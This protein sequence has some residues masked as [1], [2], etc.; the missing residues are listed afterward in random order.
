[1]NR[2]DFCIR[3]AW[4]RGVDAIPV[5]VEISMSEALPG[6]SVLGMTSRDERDVSYRVRCAIRAC[7]FE[8]PRK[9][10]TVNLA[11]GDTKKAGSGFDLPIAAAILAA[12]AQIPTQGLDNTLFAGEL[13][14]YGDVSAVRGDIAY[15]VLARD[16]SLSFVGGLGDSQVTLAG[17]Q[18]L[19]LQK[20]SDL[21]RGIEYLPSFA[22]QEAVANISEGIDFAEVHGQETAKRA[23]TIAAAGE[24]GM[25]MVG[26]PG[27][28]KS[29]LAER[30]TTILPPITEQEQLAALCIHSIAGNDIEPILA[31]IRPFRAPHHTT[32]AVGLVGGGRPVS[33][34]E[35]SLAHGGV[36]FLDEMAEFSANILQTLRQPMERGYVR[37]VRAEGG[38]CFPC[39]FQLLAASNP[40][41]CGYLGDREV[42]CKC[43]D[44]AVLRYQEKLRGPLADRIDI[45]VDIVRP[46]AE[47]IIEG[48]HS[49]SSAEM[50]EQVVCGRAFAKWRIQN[51]GA[52]SADVSKEKH[53]DDA[54]ASFL[55]ENAAKKRLIAIARATHMTGRGIN[56][57][58]RIARTIADM[59]ES[60]RVE[61][62]HVL[63]AS[64]FRGRRD[65]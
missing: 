31:G 40:C 7:G 5:T 49:T 50:C 42:P 29:M 4:I 30:M 38:Y 9:A 26:S 17:A 48:S 12:T 51:R 16:A 60:I 64:M 20:L 53:V 23:L 61:E 35:I 24:L 52:C 43:S 10:I 39:R 36:L 58:C 33:P 2:P 65:E 19:Y 3:T 27:S 28:G 21:K 57:V 8:M 15:Q 54:I 47:E 44:V 11:P 41:P 59:N 14:L 13:G 63:E 56:R 34:G 55:F 6:I 18:R 32:S 46:D 45:M 37:I 1:M 22:P 62:D 25:L